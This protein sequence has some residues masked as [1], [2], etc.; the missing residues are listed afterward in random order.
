MIGSLV[1]HRVNINPRFFARLRV[2]KVCAGLAL[3]PI[4][5]EIHVEV[6]LGLLACTE[7]TPFELFSKKTTTEHFQTTAALF[8]GRLADIISRVKNGTQIVVHQHF[9]CLTNIHKH[10]L[11]V[12][13]WIFVRMPGMLVKTSKTNHFLQQTHHSRAKRR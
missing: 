10:M 8:F 7:K 2:L 12:G 1:S 6:K 4:F 5:L 13:I 9:V 11:C 3:L